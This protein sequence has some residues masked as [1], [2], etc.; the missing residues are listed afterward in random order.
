MTEYLWFYVPENAIMWTMIIVQIKSCGSKP[1]RNTWTKLY[2]A[3]NIGSWVHAIMR[4][5][6]SL[7]SSKS[8]NSLGSHFMW[9]SH[10]RSSFVNED[11]LW[12]NAVGAWYWRNSSYKQPNCVYW[13]YYLV[14][15]VL[16]EIKMARAI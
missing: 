4:V 10:A 2:L 14:A 8:C 6:H 7:L 11:I 15:C 13:I 16:I 1:Q 12:E 5:F 3:S 9:A